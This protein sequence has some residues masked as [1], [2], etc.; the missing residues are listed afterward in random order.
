MT[1][2]GSGSS[3]SGNSTLAKETSP[4]SNF[5][6]FPVSSSSE[7]PKKTGKARVLTSDEC[8]K[9]L[10]EKERM[11]QEEAEGKAK[12]HEERL[13]KKRLREEARNKVEEIARKKAE[14]EAAKAAKEAEKIA[15]QAAKAA[16]R[17]AKGAARKVSER[18]QTRAG[19]KRKASGGESG[20]PKKKQSNVDVTIYGCVLCLL[21][22]L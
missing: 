14:R 22:E 4:L 21:W 12:H 2:V 7:K 9:I 1:P 3:S 16:E 5:L 8:L 17:A 20:S 11:K 10:K 13:K 18:K 19:N 6:V 15:R